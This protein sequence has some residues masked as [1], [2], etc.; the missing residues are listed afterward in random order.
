MSTRIRRGAAWRR[1]TLLGTLRDM[2]YAAGCIWADYRAEARAARR[3]R[4]AW[5]PPLDLHAGWPGDRG[6][7]AAVAAM[8]ALAALGVLARVVLGLLTGADS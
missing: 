2:A 3:R 6:R 5:P 7:L 1:P 8:A 4:R